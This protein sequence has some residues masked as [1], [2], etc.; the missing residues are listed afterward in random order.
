MFSRCIELSPVREGHPKQFSLTFKEWDTRHDRPEPSHYGRPSASSAQIP[1]GDMS[2]SNRVK[3][4]RVSRNARCRPIERRVLVGVADLVHSI[5][6]WMPDKLPDL[7]MRTPH[8]KGGFLE[9]VR[10]A[11]V[12]GIAGAQ[13]LIVLIRLEQH[14][15]GIELQ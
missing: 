10:F 9:D 5:R 8:L 15:K 13:P 11:R 12:T 14:L 7:V 3:Q 6:P 2:A 1:N 4:T